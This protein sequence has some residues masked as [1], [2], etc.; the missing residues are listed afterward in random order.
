MTCIAISSSESEVACKN[1][2][3]LK[4]VLCFLFYW[5]FRPSKSSWAKSHLCLVGPRPA[6]PTPP[7]MLGLLAHTCVGALTHWEPMWQYRS[8]KP[9]NSC[10][11]WLTSSTKLGDNESDVDLNS[12]NFDQGLSHWCPTAKSSHACAGKKTG[13]WREGHGPVEDVCDLA[14]GLTIGLTS[15]LSIWSTRFNIAVK[16]CLFGDRS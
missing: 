12:C 9:L 4:W 5:S 10:G 6:P 8:H 1:Y 7:S 3:W 2:T 15:E 13:H 16:T 14:H 11:M